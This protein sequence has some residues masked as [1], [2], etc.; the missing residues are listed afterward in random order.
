ML[1]MPENVRAACPADEDALIDLCRELHTE[2]A[3]FSLDIDKVR[4]IIQQ[5]IKP[6]PYHNTIRCIGVIGEPKGPLEGA[7]H[8]VGQQDWYSSEW[9]LFEV[10]NFVPTRYRKG[11]TNARDLVA[12]AKGMAD[13]LSMKLLIGIVSNQRTE[14]KV[15]L[16]SRLLGPP[17]G[18]FFFYGGTTGQQGSTH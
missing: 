12:W 3:A 1:Q 13:A 14:A 8:L 9:A 7:I 10:F 17:A 11:T 6:P 18:A 16:Y 2:N 4:E 5:A 15:R